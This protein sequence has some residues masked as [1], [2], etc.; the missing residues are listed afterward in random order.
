[1]TGTVSCQEVPVVR[2]TRVLPTRPTLRSRLAAAVVTL[3]AASFAAI[4]AGAAPTAVARTGPVDVVYV[5]SGKVFPDAL[6]AGPLAAAQNAPILL[7]NTTSIPDVTRAA[8]TALEP[9]RILVVGGPATVSESVRVE[10]QGYAGT[11]SVTRIQGP[12]R[13]A[14]AAEVADRLPDVVPGRIYHLNVTSNGTLRPSYSSP[15]LRDTVI[16]RPA[17]QPSG[18]YCVNVPDG[19]FEPDGAIATL[20][21]S[22][23][24]GSGGPDSI[25]VLTTFN[26]LCQD[27]GLGEIDVRTSDAAGTMQDGYFTLLVPGR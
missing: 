13:Y 19:L 25:R 5:A 27:A 18:H 4:V 2:P 8:L 22:F 11:G 3:L 10:L 20:Q 12:N 9:D 7:V 16:V 14:V 6:V 21:S 23:A 15:E 24:S 1:M 17:G 26:G